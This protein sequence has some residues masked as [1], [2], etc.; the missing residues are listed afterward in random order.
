MIGA[1]P[2]VLRGEARATYSII[3]TM[4]CNI[5]LTSKK[6]L[7]YLSN[8][9]KPFARLAAKGLAKKQE[10]KPTHYSMQKCKP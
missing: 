2:T 5:D 7:Y 9:A 6:S 3:N 4:R 8:P 1:L 10:W